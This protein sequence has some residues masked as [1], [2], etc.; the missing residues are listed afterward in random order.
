M[1]NGTTESSGG[2]TARAGL[3]PCGTAIRRPIAQPQRSF[4]GLLGGLIRSLA[5]PNFAVVASVV[6]PQ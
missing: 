5:A 6:S 4:R 3:T 2:A 1:K